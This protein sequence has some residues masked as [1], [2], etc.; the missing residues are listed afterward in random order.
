MARKQGRHLANCF[1][2]SDDNNITDQTSTVIIPASAYAL[3]KTS[4]TTDGHNG[5][6]ARD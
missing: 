5:N 1:L 3:G 4:K 6:D 2:K